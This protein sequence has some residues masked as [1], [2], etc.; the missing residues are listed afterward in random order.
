MISHSKATMDACVY[1]QIHT[2]SYSTNMKQQGTTIS[3][4]YKTSI[5]NTLI[6][7]LLYV[8]RGI[9]TNFH[10]VRKTNE[11]I[12]LI[13]LLSLICEYFSPGSVS[14]IGTYIRSSEPRYFEF[15]TSFFPSCESQGANTRKRGRLSHMLRLIYLKVFF[16]AQTLD[17]WILLVCVW[18]IRILE[19]VVGFFV[20]FFFYFFSAE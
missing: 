17:A 5:S 11:K 2:V 8:I 13:F 9:S 6:W 18:R 7:T 1:V 14:L 12:G 19:F 16:R 3:Q 10:S 20:F 4:L 15:C